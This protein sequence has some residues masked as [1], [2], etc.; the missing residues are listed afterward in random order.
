[1]VF[2]DNTADDGQTQAGAALLRRKIRQKQLLLR[3]G[4][5]PGSAVRHHDL[6]DVAFGVNRG[7]DPDFLENRLLHGLGSIVDQVYHSTLDLGGI[8]IDGRQIGRELM[9]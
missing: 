4:R 5:Y 2:G 7:P 6:N 3:L 9:L 8:N 1:M